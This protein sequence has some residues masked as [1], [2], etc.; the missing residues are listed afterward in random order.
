MRK[1]V[2]ALAGV[3][4]VAF[5]AAGARAGDKEDD[6]ENGLRRLKG[7]YTF[8]L[9]P[10]TS[11]APVYDGSSGKPDSGVASAPRQDILRIGVFTSDGAGN[12]SGHAIATTDDGLVTLIIDF[13]FSGTYTVNA[14]GTGIAQLVPGTINSCKDGNGGV[15]G[16][17]CAAF[18]GVEMF[19]FVLNSHG[20]DKTVDLIQIDNAGGGAKIFLTGQAKKRSSSH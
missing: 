2:L 14:D 19:A 16:E 7:T 18:E 1:L 6:G 3:C 11:F 13:A 15:S 9:T 5:T 4:L 8:R 10:A 17:D 12:L 20:D